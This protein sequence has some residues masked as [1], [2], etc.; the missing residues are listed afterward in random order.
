VTYPDATASQ[1]LNTLFIPVQLDVTK[2]PKR[3]DQFQVI[4]TPNLNI[5]DTR[6]RV[7]FHLEGWLS[8]SEFAAMLLLGLG[9]HGLKTKRYDE[10]IAHFKSV[11]DRY[12][13][14]EFAPEALYYLAVG[15]CGHA[16]AEG[17]EGTNGNSNCDRAR[18]TLCRFYVNA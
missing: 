15:P 9:H 1:L 14:S 13:Q 11:Y 7:S 6:E 12:P 5:V 10:A 16:S 4:W 8:P 3:A 2:E 18:S 17:E